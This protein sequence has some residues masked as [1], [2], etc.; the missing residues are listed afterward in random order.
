MKFQFF[1][2]GISDDHNL[3]VYIPEKGVV[4]N[5]L[6]FPGRPN[7]YSLRGGVYRDPLTW[8]DGLKMIR[9]LEPEVVLNTHAHAIQ[10][11]KDEVREV[12]PVTSI[13]SCHL[14]SDSSRHPARPGP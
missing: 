11:T 10:G 2:E 12:T 4:L 14:Q 1:T 7:V 8:R 9:D 5:N 3:T 13:A 6:V